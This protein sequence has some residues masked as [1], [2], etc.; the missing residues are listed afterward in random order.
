VG[1]YVLYNSCEVRGE[2][3]NKIKEVTA[4]VN[5]VPQMRVGGHMIY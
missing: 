2:Y 3:R 5:R 1:F 4:C